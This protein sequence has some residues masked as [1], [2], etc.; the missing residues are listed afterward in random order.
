MLPEFIAAW[1]TGNDIVYAIRE[2]R[3]EGWLK[4]TAY[5][6]FYR[7]LR[8]V[9]NVDIPLDAGD[10]CIMDRKVVR[11]LRSMPERNRFVRGLRSWVGLCQTGLA[12]KRQARHAGRPKYTWSRLM[13]LAL[14]GFVSFSHMPLRV[15]SL[16]GLSISL[17]SF[18]VAGFK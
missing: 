2:E 10:F 15:A 11:L 18:L 16:M 1:R 13:L 12:Y 9:A 7:M 3:K 4:R 6:A 5:T 14:D 8:R 17:L